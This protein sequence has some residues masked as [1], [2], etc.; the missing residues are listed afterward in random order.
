MAKTE[1]PHKKGITY[2]SIMSDTSM[3]ATEKRSI[4][5]IL[6]LSKGTIGGIPKSEGGKQSTAKEV[7]NWEGRKKNTRS[8]GRH[9]ALRNKI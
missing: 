3:S 1:S 8:T 2:D 6:G 7:R 5:K 4:I 9:A